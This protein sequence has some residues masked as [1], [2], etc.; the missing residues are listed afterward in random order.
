MKEGEEETADEGEKKK[1]KVK[2]YIKERMMK[3]KK[4]EKGEITHLVDFLMFYAKKH[5]Q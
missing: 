2:D 5:Y 1:R 4:R 3:L